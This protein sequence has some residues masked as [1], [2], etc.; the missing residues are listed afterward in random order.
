[1]SCGPDVVALIVI[2]SIL[3]DLDFDLRLNE[4]SSYSRSIL[5]DLLRRQQLL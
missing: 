1:M 5:N 2:P 4:W 3:P